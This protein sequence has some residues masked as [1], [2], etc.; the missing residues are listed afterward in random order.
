MPSRLMLVVQKTFASEPNINDKNSASSTLH[1]TP[2]SF[3]TKDE[4][5]DMQK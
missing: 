5:I 3:V 2:I 1:D 4:P